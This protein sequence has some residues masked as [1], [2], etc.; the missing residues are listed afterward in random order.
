M[1]DCLPAGVETS[2]RLLRVGVAVT[3]GNNDPA[4][5]AFGDKF[6]RARQFGGERHHRDRASLEQRQ[7]ELE[8]RFD[9]ALNW[10]CSC[11]QGR[12][13]GSFEVDAENSRP[14]RLTPRQLSD[15]LL[16]CSRAGYV[17]TRKGWLER[18][19][20]VAGKRSGQSRELFDRGAERVDSRVAVHLQVDEPWNSYP[21][22][23]GRQAECEHPPVRDGHVAGH[24][25]T[26]VQERGD[27]KPAMVAR[28]ATRRTCRCPLGYSGRL[29]RGTQPTSVR[30]KDFD[31]LFGVHARHGDDA[32][33]LWW[34]VA[35]LECFSGP[36][37]CR[38]IS[39]RISACCLTR[40]WGWIVFVSRTTQSA[41]RCETND[42]VPVTPVCQLNPVGER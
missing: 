27:A 14:I 12:E 30:H 22:V 40:R 25:P 29:E 37:T 10:M 26:L 32:S 4:A 36:L 39:A 24:E 21:P 28:A 3:E 23:A 9:E 41:S 19:D 15:A 11:P 42:E 1:G 6:E 20:S 17:T 5:P 8:V 18:K 31:R 34:L 38:W 7:K 33:G 16:G 35:C 2:V 13:E